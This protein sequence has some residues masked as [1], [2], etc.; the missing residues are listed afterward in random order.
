MPGVAG[1]IND[2]KRPHP[3][4]LGRARGVL[5]ENAPDHL[6]VGEHVEVVV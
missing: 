4:K 2:H 1:V 6:T 5:L 3:S